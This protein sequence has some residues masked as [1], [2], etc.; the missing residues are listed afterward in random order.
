MI[1]IVQPDSDLPD[2][3]AEGIGCD[4]PKKSEAKSRL[5]RGQMELGEVEAV[6][7]EG[8]DLDDDGGAYLV[9]GNVHAA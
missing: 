3:L 5:E 8:M 9:D 1:K 4:Q 6:V 2:C 7:A